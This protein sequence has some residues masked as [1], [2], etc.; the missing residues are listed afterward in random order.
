MRIEPNRPEAGE[1]KHS[2]RTR[3]MCAVR[4]NQSLFFILF[5]RTT[6][7]WGKRW[8]PAGICCSGYSALCPPRN[9][10]R[11]ALSV[12]CVVLSELTMQRRFLIGDDKQVKADRHSHPILEEGQRKEQPSLAERLRE[13]RQCKWDCAPSGRDQRQQNGEARP[14]VRE[15]LSWDVEALY[16]R[17]AQWGHASPEFVDG[18]VVK[19]S[20]RME[21]ALRK[22]TEQASF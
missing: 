2:K 6:W 5:L 14:T 22:T 16:S 8:E 1:S 17:D 4:R 15:C 19:A 12:L 21:K 9:P 10:T 18:P 13:A 11:D 20:D 3:W 7:R